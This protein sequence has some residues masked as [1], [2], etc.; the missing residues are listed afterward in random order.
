MCFLLKKKRESE[1]VYMQPKYIPNHNYHCEQD[2]M[3]MS[4]F[5]LKHCS[6][7]VQPERA[8]DNG[9]ELYLTDGNKVTLYINLYS[10]VF[11][12]LWLEEF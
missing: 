2:S 12:H 8:T 7:Y 3:L 11:D 5:S 4:A 6:A 10:A 9:W 1:N